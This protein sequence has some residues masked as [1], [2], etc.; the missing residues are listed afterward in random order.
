MISGHEWRDAFLYGLATGICGTL[1]LIVLGVLWRAGWLAARAAAE[2]EDHD[3]L[4]AER[5]RRLTEQDIVNR[6]AGNPARQ[7]E[8][9]R[10]Q[11]V[12]EGAP[13]ICGTVFEINGLCAAKVHTRISSRPDGW[14]FCGFPIRSESGLVPCREIATEGCAYCEKHAQ[15]PKP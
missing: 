10:A 12:G 13:C 7:V 9:A 11:D 1:A 15:W 6:A 14:K 2:C 5:P 8:R 4:S 3:Q